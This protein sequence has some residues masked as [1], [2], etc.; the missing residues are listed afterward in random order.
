MTCSSWLVGYKPPSNIQYNIVQSVLL[1][2]EDVPWEYCYVRPELKELQR[3]NVSC[4]I[5][6]LCI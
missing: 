1:L 6:L 2:T 5:G 3:R 4:I